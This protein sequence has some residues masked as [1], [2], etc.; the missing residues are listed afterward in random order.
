MCHYQ[1]IALYQT[2]FTG[3]TYSG[4]C[5]VSGWLRRVYMFGTQMTQMPFPV[6]CAHI[7]IIFSSPQ[8]YTQIPTFLTL[9]LCTSPF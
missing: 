1:W 5:G 7:V 6:S 8:L 9:F 3:S 4:F 2:T